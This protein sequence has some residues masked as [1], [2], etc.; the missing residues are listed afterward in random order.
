M[1]SHFLRQKEN[2]EIWKIKLRLDVYEVES[3]L[4][5]KSVEL[6]GYKDGY[7]GDPNKIW[8]KR[9]TVGPLY[10]RFYIT[11]STNHTLEIDLYSSH[12]IGYMGHNSLQAYTVLSIREP[13]NDS[14]F[15]GEFHS[16]YINTIPL[17]IWD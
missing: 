1:E 7:T 13:R 3:Y 6:H 12:H 17:S 5:G 14:K 9:Q 15:T 4:E 11:D 10:P 8:T 2:C 16:S